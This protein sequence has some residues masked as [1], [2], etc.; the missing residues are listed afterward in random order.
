MLRELTSKNLEEVHCCDFIR[1]EIQKF[2]IQL[3]KFKISKLTGR[4]KI[5][6]LHLDLTGLLSD[7]MDGNF[8]V[9]FLSL[10]S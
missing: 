2:L 6:H 1:T 3:K 4:S 8:K 5:L 10:V 9:I 7:L